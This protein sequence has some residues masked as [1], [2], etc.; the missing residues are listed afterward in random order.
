MFWTSLDA[1]QR[2]LRGA[3][4]SRLKAMRDWA[5]GREAASDAPGMGR[6][7]KA[8]RM[9]RQMREAAEELLADRRED[10]E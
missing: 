3:D 4:E 8:R 2:D 1:F 7:P 6:N 9:F 5:A 10:R